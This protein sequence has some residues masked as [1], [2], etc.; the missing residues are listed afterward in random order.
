MG[1]SAQLDISRIRAELRQIISNVIGADLA[2]IDE[3]APLLDYVTSSL[4]L[5]EGIRT[6][7]ER[8][9]VMIPLRPLLEGAGNL[10]AL[11]AFIDQ[12]INAHEKTLHAAANPDRPAGEKNRQAPLTPP[13]QHVGFLA[14][15]S[16]EACSAYNEPLAVRLAGSLHA[17]A[18]QAAIEAAG[19][20]HEVTRAA[21]SPDSDTIT[22]R[23]ERLQLSAS[24]CSADELSGR[25]ADIATQAFHTGERL[26][27][28]QLLRLSETEHVLVLVGHAVV[29]DHEA[30]LIILEDIAELYTA[31]SRGEQAPAARTAVELTEYMIRHD[32]AE[33]NPARLAAEEYWKKGLAHA[34]RLE[35]PADHARPP[36]KGYAGARLVV[37]VPSDVQKAL[38]SWPGKSPEAI[39]FGAFTAVMPRAARPDS[40]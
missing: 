6:V 40:T 31:F 22:L 13:Q 33:E 34:S 18:L 5:L 37:P 27:R 11:S 19:E 32:G 1:T 38:E 9:G 10:R 35:L 24:G 16:A 12:A 20:R 25:V 21:L 15:Y 8:F 28:A 26:F 30:L 39:L 14:R 7:Y 36:I 3:D 2:D 4:A 17:P 23:T 29:V